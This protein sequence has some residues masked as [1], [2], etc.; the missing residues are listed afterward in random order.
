M[1]RVLD[2]FEKY[3]ILYVKE[4]EF[5]R[6]ENIFCVYWD[7]DACSLAEI[8]LDIQGKCKAC[9]YVSVDEGTLAQKRQEF[10]DGS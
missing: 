9:L 8:E 3:A 7:G 6:C 10:L 5:M 4:G 2:I 1:L